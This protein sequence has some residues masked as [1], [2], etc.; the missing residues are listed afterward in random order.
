MLSAENPAG[1]RAAYDRRRR[2]K[3]ANMTTPHRRRLLRFVANCVFLAATA[4]Y[5]WADEA[6]APVELGTAPAGNGLFRPIFDGRTLAG[7]EGNASWWRVEDE[8]ITGTIPAGGRLDAN[9]FIWWQGQVG[10]FELAFEYRLT[11]DPSINSGIQYRS[12]RRDDGHAQGYQADLDDGATWLGRIY[13]EEGRGLLLERGTRVAISPSGERWVDEFASPR[14]IR[15][16]MQPNAWNRYAIRARSSHVTIWINGTLAAVLDDRDATHARFAGGLSFQLHSGQGPARVQFRNI[17]LRDLGR[18]ADPLVPPVPV[19]GPQPAE[20]EPAEKETNPEKGL[21][22]DRTSPVLWHLVANPAPASPIKN[23]AA[24]QSAAGTKVTPGFHVDLVAAEPDIRQPIAFAIDERGRIW[25]VEAHS[26]PNRRPDGQGLDRIVILE[27]A[28]AD[29]HYETRKVF[30]EKLN[31]VSGIEVG[32][33]GVWVGAAPHLLFFADR[34][35]DDRPDGEPEILLDGWGYQDTHETLNSFL[36]GPDGWLYGNHG[37]FTTSNVGP[38]GSPDDKRQQ[39][40]AG[41]WRYH[42]VSRRFEVF[43]A[44]GS[45]QWGLDYNEVGDLFMTHCRSFFG[46]GGSSHAI[47]GGHLWNQ[48]NSGHAPFICNATDTQAFAPGMPNYLPAAARYD[49]GEG[50]AGKPGSA[51]VYGGH[52]PVGTLVYQG[53]NWPEIY[54]GHIF[55]NNLHGRQMNHQEAVR[56]GSGYE[57]F[58][59]GFDILFNPDFQY[60][61]VDL[62]CG[63]DGAVIVSDWCDTQHCHVNVNEKWDRGNGRL[64]R[65]AWSDT[66]KPVKVDLGKLSD[67]ELVALHGHRNQWHVRTARRLLQERAAAGRLDAEAIAPLVATSSASEPVAALEAIWTLH[68]IGTLPT[69]ALAAAARHPS[70]YVRGWAVALATEMPGRPTLPTTTLVRLASSDPSAWVRRQLAS[71]LVALPEADRWA[72]AES[73]AT[74]GEDARDRFLPKLIWSGIAELVAG[75]V[76]RAM[77]MAASTPLQGLGDSIRWYAARLSAGRDAAVA[78]ILA[79]PTNQSGRLLEVLALGI[80]PRSSPTAPAG[81]QEVMARFE[82]GEEAAVIDR[83]SAIFGDQAVLKRLRATLAD[84]ARPVEERRRALDVLR[85]VGDRDVATICVELLGDPAFRRDAIPL[86]RSSGDPAVASTLL[87]AWPGLDEKERLAA[88]DTLTAKPPFALP[89]MQAIVGGSVGDDQL[90]AVHRRALRG[91]GDAEITRLANERWGKV[92]ES[93]AAL[94]ARMAQIEKTYWEA[95]HWAIDVE[96][97][98]QVFMK[99]CA[100]CHMLGGQ[101]GTIGQNLTGSGKNGVRYFI[102]NVVDPN[103]VI[104]PQYQMSVITTDDGA[105][106]NGIVTE[107]TP[108]AVM[109]R[110]LTDTVTIPK[111]RIEERDLSPVSMMPTGLLDQLPGEDMLALL[112]FLVKDP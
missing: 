70:E 27:D 62:Q 15:E 42:P 31:L 51:A 83:L 19:A 109:I 22:G 110:T 90:H 41:V 63:P 74:H 106:V 53:D 89:L 103:S 4:A 79:C 45:N 38:P 68:A 104:G 24:Q 28:D 9:Q 96:R 7:W 60:L 33:G 11:G 61:A 36:W 57:V 94:K 111:K 49:G 71:A 23:P 82:P 2:P 32:F 40:K 21:K 48:T 58:P 101:G 3:E 26:Y 102:E 72:V 91:L 8:A 85:L 100:S 55:T 81:W 107:E 25:V 46:G 52:S 75:D 39:I 86:V 105:V 112:H 6:A 67:A 69:A 12:Q 16:A 29:G 99:N 54:R 65:V 14:A 17:L 56:T 80:D 20:R 98:R 77:R 59:A 73:L 66:W 47:R 50:G 44:G 97:G 87:A 34:D 1:S 93:P 108:A 92:N 76:A 88:L 95:P 43:A 30:V 64:F 18:T 37:V 78:E 84:P 5:G 35:G 10:D 13:E